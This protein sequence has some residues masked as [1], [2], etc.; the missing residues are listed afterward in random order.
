[1]L[2]INRQ[3]KVLLHWARQTPHTGLN[4]GGANQVEMTNNTF[5]Y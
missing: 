3:T 4:I 2:N 5:S 1:M